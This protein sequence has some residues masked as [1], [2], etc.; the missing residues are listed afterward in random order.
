M[1]RSRNPERRRFWEAHLQAWQRSGLTQTEYCG[2]QGL[3]RRG[4]CF[5]KRRLASLAATERS[6][7]R[8][9]PVAIRPDAEVRAADR[10]VAPATGLTLVT[11]G[12]RI[13]VGDRFVPDTL[14]RLL[15]TLGRL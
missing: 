6:S 10:D 12:Y 14:T 1:A 13:E 15:S 4:F 7:V 9:V 8:F 11:G 3:S 2:R 5:W